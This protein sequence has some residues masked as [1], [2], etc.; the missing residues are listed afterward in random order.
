[1]KFTCVLIT[2]LLIIAFDISLCLNNQLTSKVQLESQ[3]LL[4]KSRRRFH[5]FEMK[6]ELKSDNTPPII[7]A[8]FWLQKIYPGLEPIMLLE[9]SSLEM[10]NKFFV[11]QGTSFYYG[12]SSLTRAIIEGNNIIYIK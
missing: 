8:N 6:A 7:Q 10:Q 12:K 9:K 4:S 3:N 1:M 2:F 11:V 5:K